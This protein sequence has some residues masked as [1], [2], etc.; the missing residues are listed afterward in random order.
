MSDALL[1]LFLSSPDP[2][3]VFVSACLLTPLL[4]EHGCAAAETEPVLYN[5]SEMTAWDR[6]KLTNRFDLG[7]ALRPLFVGAE[8]CEGARA[9]AIGMPGENSCIVDAADTSTEADGAPGS[10]VS[11]GINMQEVRALRLTYSL[12]RLPD[13]SHAVALRRPDRCNLTHPP[14]ARAALGRAAARW[15]RRLH[16]AVVPTQ[17]D[18][19]T[20]AHGRLCRLARDGAAA[21]RVVRAP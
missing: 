8:V 19:D 12:L 15:R 20:H 13:E 14:D 2:T 1:S 9:A 3:T 18:L 5:S 17:R 4:I 7:P 6:Y 11:M 21:R 16:C 10:C